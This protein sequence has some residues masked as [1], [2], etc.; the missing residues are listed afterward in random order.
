MHIKIT[1]LI[2]TLGLAFTAASAEESPQ[3][4]LMA[5]NLAIDMFLQIPR[6]A[7]KA[8]SEKLPSMGEELERAYVQFKERVDETAKKL[9]ASEAFEVMTRTPVPQ[10]VADEIASGTDRALSEL[11]PTTTERGCRANLVTFLAQDGDTLNS[12]VEEALKSFQK[13]ITQ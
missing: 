8:C 10:D 3:K 13:L 1:P 4:S 6:A 11:T 7:S 2:A 12:V 5:S 9:L